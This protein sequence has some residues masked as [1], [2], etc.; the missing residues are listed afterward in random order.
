MFLSVFLFALLFV[1][2]ETRILQEMSM[3]VLSVPT[4]SNSAGT[5]P[6][7]ASRK[8]GTPRRSSSVPTACL[9]L[10]TGLVAGAGVARA[11][12]EVELV[13]LDYRSTAEGS[14][15]V[16]HTGFMRM[17]DGNLWMD[18]GLGQDG[19]TTSIY[20][21]EDQSLLLVDH[22]RKTYSVMDERA[23]ELIT[24]E[25]QLAMMNLDQRMARLPPEQ[26]K[27]LQDAFKGDTPDRLAS[28]V[29]ATPEVA[30]VSGFST[31]KFDV[32]QGEEK[33]REVWVVD[34][35]RVP[36]EKEVLR[37]LEGVDSLFRRLKSAYESVAS[38]TLGGARPFELGESPFADLQAMNGFP[39]RTRN[40]RDGKLLSETRVVALNKK[41]FE[42]DS[43]KAPAG[44]EKKVMRGE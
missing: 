7:R 37:C 40:F 17:Q 23:I 21:A 5:N 13:S 38:A 27:L 26:R 34:W 12:V 1:F 15:A 28:K 32:F 30:T 6:R 8:D 11:G 41:T 33:I 29:E 18:L 44:Y 35:S 24:D 9:A 16:E 3:P 2:A 4:D 36:E 39:V 31:R 19:E 20:R 42:S 10:L 43:F 14:Q 25:M 22:S